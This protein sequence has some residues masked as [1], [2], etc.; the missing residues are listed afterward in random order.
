MHGIRKACSIL[1]PWD[2]GFRVS[3]LR[4]GGL[5][6]LSRLTGFRR[7]HG[8]VRVRGFRASEIVTL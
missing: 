4:S 3:N 2:L 7:N 1:H 5:S 8:A 6:F